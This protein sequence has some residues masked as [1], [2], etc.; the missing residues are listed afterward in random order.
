M[1]EPTSGVKAVLWR[2]VRFPLIRVVLGF[3]VVLVPVLLYQ[4][5]LEKVTGGVGSKSTLF[6]IAVLPLC[7]LA[8]FAYWGFVRLIE[9]R[10]V[11]ELGLVGALR[12]WLAGLGIG[13]LMFCATIGLI[14]ALGGYSVLGYNGPE[15]LLPFIGLALVSGVVEEILLR[16][17]FFR[18]ME[19]WLGSWVALALSAALFGAL[20]LTNPNASFGAAIA[21]AL[22]AGVMLGA[23]YMVTRR[24]WLPIGLHMA[25]NFVQGGIFGVAVS[26][27]ESEGLLISRLSGPEWVSG[28]AFGAEAS[29]LA[30]LVGIILSLYF[31]RIAAKR[32]QIQGGFWTR[33]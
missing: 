30:V 33:R 10:A 25:W 7:A 22:E 9:Q 20:H 5:G 29:M 17:L 21:I 14:A 23:A 26:G 13:T 19:E 24:L 32:G 1:I 3:F 6:P 16:G 27:N 2:I 31:L 18:I 28:G 8:F 15:K 4:L 11:S 12:E